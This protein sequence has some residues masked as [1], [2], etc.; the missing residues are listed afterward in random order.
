M[1]MAAAVAATL[2]QFPGSA[3][4]AGRVASARRM[5]DTVH[6][7]SVDAVSGV[8]DCRLGPAELEGGA[9][10]ICCRRSPGSHMRAPNHRNPRVPIT[11]PLGHGDVDRGALRAAHA[12]G[13]GL[14]GDIGADVCA[15]PWPDELHYGVDQAVAHDL[16]RRRRTGNDLVNVRGSDGLLVVGDARVLDRA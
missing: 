12:A 13:G 9:A 10:S 4:P 5:A 15:H 1:L 7:E 2:A 11:E 8:C 6:E 14:R 3:S 16:P